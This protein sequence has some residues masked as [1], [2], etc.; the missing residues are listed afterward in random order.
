M[1]RRARLAIAIAIGIGIAAIAI[2]GWWLRSR[3]V[4]A[5]PA[6]E[7][8][9]A[10]APEAVRAGRPPRGDP[11]EPRV[12]IDDDPKGS[13]QLEGQVI[14]AEDHGVAGAV[15]VIAA[16][17]PRSMT[18]EADGSFAFDGLVARPYTL[19]ARAAQGV[20]GP[21]TARL[22]AKSEPVVL[23]LRPAARL[24]VTVVGSDAVP[25]SGAT[26]ELRGVDVQRAVT[27]AGPAVFSPVVPG[28]YQIAAWADGKAHAFQRIAIG[29]GDAQA[30]LVLS[31]GAAVTG[32]VVDDRGAGIAG[33]HVRYSGASDWTQQA[34]ERHDAAVTAGDGSFRFE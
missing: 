33:A 12:M 21:I 31:A 2:G 14:D 13:L 5:P 3:R 34:S 10:T 29:R 32:R 22:T 26:V 27:K 17:P 25:I 18:T 28:G 15:V 30:R 6:S 1:S 8:S 19:I 16:N 11:G 4:A 9:A 7:I 20:A 23:R 24:T